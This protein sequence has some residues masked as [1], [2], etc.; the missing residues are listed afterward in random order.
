MGSGETFV[1]EM[2]GHDL[3]CSQLCTYRIHEWLIHKRVMPCDGSLTS[4]QRATITALANSHSYDDEL[5]RRVAEIAERSDGI[6]DK[7]KF[8]QELH[9]FLVV[10][11]AVLADGGG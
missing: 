5:K 6:E 3:L 8:A 11:L 9:H 7:V 10:S 4:E 1:I 2:I